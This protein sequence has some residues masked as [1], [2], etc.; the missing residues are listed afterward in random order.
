MSYRRK[1]GYWRQ[2]KKEGYRSRASY[3][4]M[5]LN[6]TFRLLKKGDAVLD[7]GCAP[8]GWM[9]AAREIVGDPGYV[10]GIDLQK[11]A[12][13]EEENVEA[14]QAD[15]T[16]SDI[17]TIIRERKEVFDVVISDISPNIS[18]IWDVYH[19]RS[20]E[21]SEKALDLAVEL[22]RNRGNFLVKVF[23]GEATRDFFEKVKAHF[24]YAKISSPKASR[25]SSAEVYVIG[26]HFSR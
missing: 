14:L 24:S 2:A 5:Q 1:D 21:L 15:I 18:G 16:R 3:K 7:I 11:I 19:F 9:Q 22:L 13:F 26:K 17:L 23:Q 4:L 12:P 20:V 10:L 8:G 6:S 25:K